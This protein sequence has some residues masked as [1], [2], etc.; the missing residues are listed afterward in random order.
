M[1]N[2]KSYLKVFDIAGLVLSETAVKESLV[3]EIRRRKNLV[4]L[5]LFIMNSKIHVHSRLI[6]LNEYFKLPFH[7]ISMCIHSWA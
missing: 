2:P 6:S 3:L 1:E 5:Y 7:I 4:K